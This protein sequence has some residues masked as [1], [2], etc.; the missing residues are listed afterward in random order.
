MGTVEHPELI[1]TALRSRG[2]VATAQ[3]GYLRVAPHFY[4]TDEGIRRVAE[5]LNQ[6]TRA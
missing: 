6:E 4:L 1:V 2:M 5:A 3:G